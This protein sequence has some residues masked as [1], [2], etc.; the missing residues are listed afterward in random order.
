[1][2]RLSGFLLICISLLLCSCGGGSAPA[3]NPGPGPDPD[4]IVQPG[5]PMLSDPS[6]VQQPG[7]ILPPAE[8]IWAAQGGGPGNTSRTALELPAARPQISVRTSISDISSSS[9][10]LTAEGNVLVGSG[11][12]LQCFADTG[13]VKWQRSLPRQLNSTPFVDSQGQILINSGDASWLV[14]D[15]RHNWIEALSPAGELRWQYDTGD[16]PALIYALLE[17]D[18]VLVRSDYGTFSLLSSSGSLLWQRDLGASALYNTVLDE[19]GNI[20][21]GSN[22]AA[23]ISL[24]AQ[25]NLRWSYSPPDAD[26]G[27]LT[28][29]R[30]L[31][32]PLGGMLLLT[33]VEGDP[34]TFRVSRLT[35]DGA[36]QG[37]FPCDEQFSFTWVDDAGNIWLHDRASRISVYNLDGQLQR[38]IESGYG[39]PFGINA[40]GRQ[41][42]Y[43]VTA[44]PDNLQEYLLAGTDNAGQEEWRISSQWSFRFP[45]RADSGLLYSGDEQSFFALDSLGR[46]HWQEIHGDRL[47]GLSVS[48]NGCIYSCG[49]RNL[50]AFS[51][52]GKLLWQV[53]ADG[54]ITAAPAIL[55]GGQLAFG[56][57]LGFFYIYENNGTRLSK[58]I[59]EEAIASSAAIAADGTMFVGTR[60]GEVFSFSAEL[61]PLRRFTT[62]APVAAG[63]AIDAEGTAYIATVDGHIH[64]LYTDGVEAWELNLGE[65]LAGPLV[66]GDEYRVFG[67]TAGGRVFALHSFDGHM[68]WDHYLGAAV[69]DGLAL[70]ADGA[71]I[72][73]T[74]EG[75]GRREEPQ[76]T[77]NGS[78][79]GIYKFS[80]EGQILWSQNGPYS[81][82]SAPLVDSRGWICCEAGGWLL[83]LDENGNEQWRLQVGFEDDVTRPVPLNSGRIA[84]CS[85]TQLLVLE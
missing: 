49:G 3:G 47:A 2:S 69:A 17:D 37:S 43:S 57:S 18:S 64:A 19:D 6:E 78:G 38:N 67:A 56:D 27:S 83:C 4:P 10:K 30:R 77:R 53:S 84:V 11:A 59:L 54:L 40:D 23:L 52:D 73:A 50:Y 85:G 14:S 1:M 71:L 51:L 33:G 62:D 45:V 46:R 55:P 32:H 41:N 13:D 66:L 75:A 60:K 12:L 82:S 42:L 25:G 34:R 20:Y 36:L 28:T 5:E 16:Y 80:A 22:A 61:T 35:A 9:A 70:A 65:P 72:V 48:G 29:N 44:S 24:D 8:V 74:D 26:P 15:S 81:F 63:I 39:F 31:L 58:Y 7:S 79:R 68:V 21:T 76:L